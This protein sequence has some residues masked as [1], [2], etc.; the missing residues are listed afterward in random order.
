MNPELRAAG[1]RA[2]F[3][4]LEEWSAIAAIGGIKFPLEWR[5]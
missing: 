5:Y 3:R 1:I 2:Q 4:N